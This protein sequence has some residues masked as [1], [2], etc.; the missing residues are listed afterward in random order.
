MVSLASIK[1]ARGANSLLDPPSQPT[2]STLVCMKLSADFRIKL[3]ETEIIDI[4]D[5]EKL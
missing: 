4:N 1:G 3:N 5:H 2:E